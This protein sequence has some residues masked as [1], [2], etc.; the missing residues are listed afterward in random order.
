MTRPLI[1]GAACTAVAVLGLSRAKFFAPA[2]S[3]PPAPDKVEQHLFAL[4]QSVEAALSGLSN[5]RA[6]I[7]TQAALLGQ[8]QE[9]LLLEPAAELE[10]LQGLVARLIAEQHSLA[11]KHAAQAAGLA[12]LAGMRSE[13]GAEVRGAIE[14]LR[15]EEAARW[16]GLNEAVTAASH[17]VDRVDGDLAQLGSRLEPTSAGSTR[18]ARMLAPT[19]RLEGVSTVGSGVVLESRPHKDGRGYQTLLLTAWHVVRDI[20]ADAIGSERLV[21]VEIRRPEGSRHELA[22]LLAHEQDL[23]AALLEL[24]TR[25]PVRHGA[26]LAGRAALDAAQ[27]FDDIY[28]VGCPLGNDPIPTHG[29]IMDLGHELDGTSYWMISAPTYIGNSGGG[30]F[31]GEGHALVAIFSKLYTHGTIRPTVIPHMGLASPLGPVCDWLE[32][33]GVARLV[34]EPGGALAHLEL[35]GD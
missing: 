12:E 25:E 13:L 21:P 20:Q 11:E 31:H 28:A 26:R 30:I 8:R 18:N 16:S 3:E 9:S 35:I 4:E 17:R 32:T 6:E 15:N 7:E 34:E 14:A 10:Q 5:L 29:E 24:K 23:D 2:A 33:S 22:R 1:L 27:V 19:V